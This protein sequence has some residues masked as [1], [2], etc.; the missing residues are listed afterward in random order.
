MVEGGRCRGGRRGG[1][2][3]REGMASAHTLATEALKEE[4][5]A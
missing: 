1:S 5:K 4:E 2:V 3:N